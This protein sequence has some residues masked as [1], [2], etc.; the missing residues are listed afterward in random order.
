MLLDKT[1]HPILT[2]YL[3]ESTQRNW[4]RVTLAG[5]IL[6]L[7]VSNTVLLSLNWEGVDQT[8]I[9]HGTSLEAEFYFD[10]EAS[11]LAIIVLRAFNVLIADLIVVRTL[12]NPQV[13]PN[14]DS[15]D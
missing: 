10:D 14:R 5:I 11:Q 4:K 8:F 3:V 12:V 7:W 2:F 9:T 6:F 1:S 13:V 15:L